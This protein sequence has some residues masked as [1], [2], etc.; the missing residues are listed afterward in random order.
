[1]LHLFIFI[2]HIFL[3]NHE[4]PAILY[5]EVIMKATTTNANFAIYFDGLCHLCSREIEMYRV[6]DTNQSIRFV[7]ISSSQFDPTLEGL[8]PEQVHKVFH[9]K[10]ESG[11]I[12]QGVEAFIAIWDRLSIFK[13][14]SFLAKQTLTRP[15]FDFGYTLFAKVRPYL[16]KRQCSDGRCHI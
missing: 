4:N 5:S 14:L 3:N 8:N 2:V 16:P 15:L 11:N 9:V 12:L 13:P 7:D 10:D 6:K 1:M